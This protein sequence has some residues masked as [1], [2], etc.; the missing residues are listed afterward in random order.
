MGENLKLFNISKTSRKYHILIYKS[1][2]GGNNHPSVLSSCR[3]IA[4]L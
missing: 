4:S 1:I 2:C 3:S